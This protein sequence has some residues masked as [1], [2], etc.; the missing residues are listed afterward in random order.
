[1]NTDSEPGQ[2]AFQIPP[3]SVFTSPR[4]RYS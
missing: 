3:E 4:N 1:V 2:F